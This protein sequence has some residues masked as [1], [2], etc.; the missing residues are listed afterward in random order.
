MADIRRRNPAARV[1]GNIG[2]EKS[3]SRNYEDQAGEPVDGSNDR[4]RTYSP[5]VIRLVPPAILGNGIASGG[6]DDPYSRDTLSIQADYREVER[7]PGSQVYGTINS[8]HRHGDGSWHTEELESLTPL[9]YVERYTRH[10]ETSAGGFLDQRENHVHQGVDIYVDAG[11]PVYA[12]FEAEFQRDSLVTSE[13]DGGRNIVL[14][15]V[16]N[17]DLEV[18]IMHLRDT[19]SFVEGQRISEGTF[20][21]LT[22]TSDNGNRFPGGTA[23]HIHLE[24]REGDEVV[25]AFANFDVSR[26]TEP[27]RTFT[28]PV[29]VEADDSQRSE[30]GVYAAAA[31]SLSNRDVFNS[32]ED[33]LRSG[34]LGS[35]TEPQLRE[36]QQVINTEG[37]L[38]TP[39]EVGSPTPAIQSRRMVAD[40]IAQI[41]EILRVPPIQL[42][43]NPQQLQLQFTKIAQFQD[44]GR[45]GYIYQ[46]WGEE[47]PVMTVQ[48]RI[49]GFV[50]T[51]GIRQ[52]INTPGPSSAPGY[53]YAAKHDSA[54]WQQFMA[55]L[56][57]YQ[58]NGYVF[59]RVFGSRAYHM[60]GTVAIDYD[61]WTYVGNFT[62]FE[63]GYSEE[64]QHGD[65]EFSFEFK[66]SRIFDNGEAN[67]KISAYRDPNRFNQPEDPKGSEP[68]SVAS[69]P[70]LP[71]SQR[72]ANFFLPP[73]SQFQPPAQ[74]SVSEPG[75]EA[76]VEEQGL[77]DAEGIEVDGVTSFGSNAFGV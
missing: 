41:I 71:F 69:S 29:R 64:K 7:P 44:R 46:A 74:S 39:G 70:R 9:D 13:Y 15:S 58:N 32:F 20:L 12:P 28:T 43:I 47:Q 6:P 25:N 65:L 42:L 38:F 77:G 3:F 68:G 60:I 35:V 2:T 18:K 21:G 33:E 10:Q 4:L 24:S 1:F 55:L 16:E 45:H 40:I 48:G 11:I 59:D 76:W 34:A 54:A 23:S 14:T 26:L 49:G 51:A 31:Q 62:S 53:Q 27:V 8:R 36:L 66:V 67:S 50:T 75:S 57:F 17:P 61:Q 30:I 72:L 37:E 52:D 56:G 5:F 63:Y 19:A 73:S 22:Y